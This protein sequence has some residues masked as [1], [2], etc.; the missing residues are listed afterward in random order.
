MREALD[1]VEDGD[2]NLLGF[3][4][5]PKNNCQDWCDRLREE[6]EKLKEEREKQ[7]EK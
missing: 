5:G 7:C 6:Y 3:G 4:E 2:Y 1:N